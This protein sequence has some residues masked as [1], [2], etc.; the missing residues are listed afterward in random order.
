M[1]QQPQFYRFFL[2]L[3][4]DEE[5]AG[6]IFELSS[7]FFPG[8]SN[9]RPIHILHL[10]LYLLIE[11]PDATEEMRRAHPP[12]EA[13][14]LLIPPFEVTLD[15]V[16]HF[17]GSK[18]VVLSDGGNGNASLQSFHETLGIE[19]RKH[20]LSVGRSRLT[21]HVTMLYDRHN[22]H[23]ETL[24]EPISWTVRDFA[25]IRSHV[26]LTLYDIVKRWPLRGEHPPRKKPTQSDFG[27]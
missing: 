10:S 8:T 22:V 27:F 13:A 24:I 6:R 25:L 2:G 12:C 18:A 15:R 26:G 3:F 23:P 7:R 9:H 4:P 1:S 11:G 16:T 21:P 20:G 5:T 14:G 19:L 17:P